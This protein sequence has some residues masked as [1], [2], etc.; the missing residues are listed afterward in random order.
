MCFVTDHYIN[1]EST[2]KTKKDKL[3][4]NLYKAVQ[5]YVEGNGGKLAVIGG[6]QILQDDPSR[7]FNYG[8]VIRCTGTLPVFAATGD[9]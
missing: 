4:D 5:A 2:V 9:K 3:I 1:P 7:K 8:V 6:V